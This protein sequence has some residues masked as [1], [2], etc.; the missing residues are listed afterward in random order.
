FALDPVYRVSPFGKV[1]HYAPGSAADDQNRV[2]VFTRDVLIQRQ[3]LGLV[4][5]LGVV[6]AGDGGVKTAHAGCSFLSGLSGLL[7][8]PRQNA[9]ARRNECSAHRAT[10]T[11]PVSELRLRNQRSA[12]GICHSECLLLQCR[13]FIASG[14]NCRHR[15]SAIE[16]DKLSY[17]EITMVCLRQPI[18]VFAKPLIASRHSHASAFPRRSRVIYA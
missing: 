8:S 12:N 11:P 2:T 6:I 4:E 15:R 3:V 9:P 1:Q 7:D 13:R 14:A 18:S 16:K 5:M 10:L 17:R